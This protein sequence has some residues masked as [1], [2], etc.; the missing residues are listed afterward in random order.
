M[1]LPL[2][3]TFRNIPPSEAIEARIREKLAKL[4]QVYDRITSCRVVLEAPH[5]HKH[6]GKI[7]AVHIDI[8]VPEGEVVVSHTSGDKHQHEDAYV[9]IR[10]AFNAARR[11]LE[12]YSRKQR[13]DVKYH[14]EAP[15]GTV[16][17]LVPEQ[18]YGRIRS[19][20]GREIYFHKNS[21]VN[22]KYEKLTVGSDVRFVEASGDDGP[23][24]STVHLMAKHANE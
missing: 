10:D 8:T 21:L 16:I 23:Q 15:H 2:Q 6:K 14:M 18:E 11:Q 5:S 7:Y 12:N 17:E 20:D 1:Q 3:I 22:E 13:G 19:A 9:A 4:E 24:A